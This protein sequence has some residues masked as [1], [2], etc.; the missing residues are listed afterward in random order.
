[1]HKDEM[2][3][4]APVPGYL[5]SQMLQMEELVISEEMPAFDIVEYG[6]TARAKECASVIHSLLLNKHTSD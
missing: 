5:T 1:M 4:L 2:G 6:E 3:A